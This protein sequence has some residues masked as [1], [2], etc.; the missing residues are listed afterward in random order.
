MST[1]IYSVRG[2]QRQPR[3]NLCSEGINNSLEEITEHTITTVIQSTLHRMLWAFM[4]AFDLLS[5]LDLST[6]GNSL[7]F[8]LR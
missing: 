7:E 6:I 3:D 5:A 8:D 1:S 2:N 4:K